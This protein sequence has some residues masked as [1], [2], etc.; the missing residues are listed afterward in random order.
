MPLLA[1]LLAAANVSAKHDDRLGKVE[2]PNSCSP[3]VQEQF[4]RGV[5]LLH[6]FY[7]FRSAE[8]FRGSFREDKSCVIAV[9]GYASI[10][11]SNPLQGN[12][13]LACGGAIGAGGDRQE[14]QERRQDPARA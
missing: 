11:M 8:G 14:P 1:L 3:A 7:Y 4:L 9:W 6:S 12:R 10:L 13:R 2:F 5:A